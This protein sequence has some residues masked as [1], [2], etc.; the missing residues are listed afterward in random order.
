MIEILLQVA[1]Q[2]PQVLNA[3]APSAFLLDFGD[4]SIDFELKFWINQPLMTKAVTSQLACEVWQAFADNN[5][6]IPFPQRDLH[7]RND[8]NDSGG[9]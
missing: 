3:P 6:E 9:L 5:I 7:I 2:N 1:R 4:S 8:G